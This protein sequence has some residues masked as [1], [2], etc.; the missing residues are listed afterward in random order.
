MDGQPPSRALRHA[1]TPVEAIFRLDPE[2][3]DW[4]VYRPGAPAFTQSIDVLRDGE[5]LLL[6]TSGDGTWRMPAR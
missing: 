1:D 4:S 2:T 6:M 3:G 5:S